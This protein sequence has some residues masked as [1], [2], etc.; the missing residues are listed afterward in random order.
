MTNT[1]CVNVLT[2]EC[3]EPDVFLNDADAQSEFERL[4]KEGDCI[5]EPG[6]D[7][8]EHQIIEIDGKRYLTADQYGEP[9][10]R[11]FEASLKLPKQ[12][13]GDFTQRIMELAVEKHQHDDPFGSL[14][15]VWDQTSDKLNRLFHGYLTEAIP[16]AL[17]EELFGEDD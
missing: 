10:A 13:F 4:V 5:A 17:A 9:F 15:P 16:E 14:A 12:S 2:D 3:G 7:Y 11:L 8:P 6:V 1:I